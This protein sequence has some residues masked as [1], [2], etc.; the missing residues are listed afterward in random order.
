MLVPSCLVG[1]IFPFSNQTILPHF[2]EFS[3]FSLLGEKLLS[4]SSFSLVFWRLFNENLHFSSEH[5]RSSIFIN[6]SVILKYHIGNLHAL[7]VIYL[8]LLE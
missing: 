5:F 1:K 7:L 8:S 3:P 2:S 4:H 6:F